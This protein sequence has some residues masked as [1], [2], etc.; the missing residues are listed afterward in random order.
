MVKCTRCNRS[1]VKGFFVEGKPYGPVCVRKLFG[2]EILQG[3]LA[4][5]KKAKP[6]TDDKEQGNFADVRA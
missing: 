5:K 4:P 1:L 2:L 3:L 6:E